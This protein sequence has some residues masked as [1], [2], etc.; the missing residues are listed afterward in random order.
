MMGTTECVGRLWVSLTSTVVG[1]NTRVSMSPLVHF[2]DT[3]SLLILIS[4][5]R[6]LQTFSSVV[7]VVVVEGKVPIHFGTKG[8]FDVMMEEILQMQRDGMWTI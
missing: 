4:Q 7:V 2:F 5:L 8:S 1:A 6:K 3:L